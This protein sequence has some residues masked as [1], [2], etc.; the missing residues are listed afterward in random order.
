MDAGAN[1]NERD[2]QVAPET[3][4]EQDELDEDIERSEGE[5]MTEPAVQTPSPDSEHAV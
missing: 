5:G 1:A 2:P 3:P 4:E